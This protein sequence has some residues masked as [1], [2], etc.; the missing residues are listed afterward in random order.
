[1]EESIHLNSTAEAFWLLDENHTGKLPLSVLG[2]LLMEVYHMRGI[3]FGELCRMQELLEEATE[4][5]STLQDGTEEPAIEIDTFRD[6]VNI[7]DRNAV[8]VGWITEVEWFLPKVYHSRWFGDLIWVMKHKRV[9]VWPGMGCRQPV[10]V[11]VFDLL[12]LCMLVASL[13]FILA[14]S[15]SNCGAQLCIYDLPQMFLLAGFCFTSISLVAVY[16]WRNCTQ[17]PEVMYGL[18]VVFLSVFT[19]FLMVI[20][21]SE[22]WGV[23]VFHS[24]R[25][26]HVVLLLKWVPR[27]AGLVQ[28]LFHM[29]NRATIPASVMFA[30]FFLM[31]VLGVQLFGGLVCAPALA[32]GDQNCDGVYI[33]SNT[34]TESKYEVLNFNNTISAIVTLFVLLVVNDW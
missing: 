23:R 7:L 28:T 33:P 2:A 27:L 14:S 10:T 34:Y 24:L 16:G 18:V 6:A 32:E 17:R 1:M 5:Q 8:H 31:A 30:W 26:A 11:L 20:G 22:Q 12:E 29:M 25:I 4:R 13:G 15:L 3:S 9:T 19:F 21:L